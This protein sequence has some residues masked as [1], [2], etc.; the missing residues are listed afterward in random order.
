MPGYAEMRE[1]AIWL[2]TDAP[3]EAK[4]YY[5]P[6]DD[7]SQSSETA[8]VTTT[9]EDAYTAELVATGLKPG[10]TYEY[11]VMLDGRPVNL[12][13][14]T[15]FS[16]PPFFRDRF[17]PPDL[18][19]ALAGGH[20]VNDEPYDPLNRI[21]GGNYEIFLAILAKDPDLMIWLGNNI[22][23]READWSSR[24]GVLARYT[25]NRAQPEL[26]PLLAAV[27]HIATWSTYDFGPEGADRLSKSSQHAR[28]GFDLFWA[29]P[30]MEIAGLEGIQTSLS[31]SDVEFFILDDR[32][33]R[34]LTSRVSSKRQ[35]LGE[36]QV[37]WLVESLRRSPATFKIVVMGSPVTNPAEAPENY[38]QVEGER[39]HL[40]EQLKTAEIGGLF[41]VSGGKAHGELTKMVRASAPDLHEL[42]LGPA[43]GRP[44]S[45]T[46]ELNYFRVPGSSV[47]QR[48]FALLDFTGPEANRQL[49]V[50]VFDVNGTEIW[51]ETFFARE[52]A[53]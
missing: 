26:Q 6:K 44:A 12:D 17:P 21:P 50:G 53:F 45:D 32:S 31:W 25:R 5:W 52:M 4:I 46:R 23:L 16:T 34:D 33:Q 9:A 11:S 35:A 24:S 37:E 48:H 14:A 28:E 40:L 49:T 42:T 1:A 29:N 27:N 39:E 3:A 7:P 22:F 41:I 36:S 2:Q 51:T 38:R 20:Y 19:V 13:Y 18:R 8:S 43:T 30:P 15:E 47:F 10:T